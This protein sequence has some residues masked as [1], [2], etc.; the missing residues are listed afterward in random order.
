MTR[1]LKRMVTYHSVY[2]RKPAYQRT[3]RMRAKHMA[4]VQVGGANG[5]E[6]NEQLLRNWCELILFR[7]REIIFCFREIISRFREIISRFREIVSR[8]RE[9]I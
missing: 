4:F 9:I 5:G 3:Q 7:F 2:Q 6:T 8:V 1:C